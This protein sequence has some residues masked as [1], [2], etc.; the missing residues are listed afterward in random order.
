MTI[1]LAPFR[2][3]AAVSLLAVLAGCAVG[4]TYQR[5]ALAV[6]AAFKETA[7]WKQAQP[8]D[9]A[10]AS[11]WWTALQDP[12]LN[13]LE[14]AV[15]TS[16]QSLLQ[17]AANYEQAR[18]LARSD[19]ATFWP[20]ISAQG[21]A[22]RS[23]EGARGGASTTTGGLTLVSPAASGPSN[24]FAASLDASWSPDFWGKI[25]RLT[26]ADVAAAQSSAAT[27]AAARLSTQASL[28]QDYIGLRLA[29]EKIRLLESAVEGYRRTFTIAKNKYTVG[30]AAKSDVISAQ[31]QLDA[32]EAQTID[33]EIQRAQLEHALAVLVGKAPSQLTIAR[34]A[35]PG[36]TIPSIPLALPS[37]LLERR[38]DV[39]AAERAVAEANARVGVQTA[40]YFPTIT[41][42]GNGGYEG[43]PLDTLFSAPNRFWTLGANLSETLLDF[44]QRRAQLQ[45]AR[46]AYDGT[47][48]NYRQTVLTA[49]QQVEDDLA[50]LRILEREAGVEATAVSEASQAASIA[51]NEYHAGTVD[52][53]T[54]V[55]AQN[56]ELTDREADLT[57]LQNRL[58]SS[59]ALMQALGGGW[60]AED[61]PSRGQ[62]MA[63]HSQAGAAVAAP[64]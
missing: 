38:P 22:Q 15:A 28:A 62:V 42:S 41:L 4:P 16:N 25:R 54:V 53:T 48:A 13:E 46:A 30:V 58:D 59:I 43:S 64:K 19:R 10:R 26:E 56:N 44:G 45:E 33:A 6:P 60:T 18:E 20:T 32:A 50:A 34:R 7:D 3:F 21:S 17:A 8:N 35:A 36:L 39:A 57:I 2:P 29:D 49:F 40:A 5:P 27:L 47:A 52:Y 55:T 37:E 24:L 51:Q 23:Q 11:A 14:Q 31:A 12:E 1:D 61:L 9:A 63:R